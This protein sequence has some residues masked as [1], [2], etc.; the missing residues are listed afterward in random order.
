MEK[1]HLRW[2]EFETN[3]RES[4]RQ[5]RVDQ[6]HFDVTLATDDGHQIEAHKI[7]LS[8]G[9]QFFDNILRKTKHPS[10][11]VYLKGINRVELEH[12]IDFLYNGEA[13]IAQEE[14][15][16]FLETAQELHVKGL[17]SKHEDVSDQ[18][19][20]VNI[21]SDLEPKFPEI[22]KNYTRNQHPTQQESWKLEEL[23]DS[24]ANSD[25]SLVQTEEDNLLLNTNLEL[26]L[27][28]EQMI[29]K[30]EELWQC[31]VCGNT[32]KL[33]R[34]LQNHVETHIEGISHTCHVCNKTCSTRNSLKVH[35]SDYHSELSFNCNIC[36]KSGMAKMAFK[37]HKRTCKFSL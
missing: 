5:L 27:Q 30:N 32:A 6:S 2:N 11:F 26:D 19:Q 33:K 17:Q 24:F 4:F 28:I 37:I 12:V 34:N 1:L 20:R 15:N 31:K 18:N 14:L 36:G 25:V 3:I 9:S 29:E 23:A 16:K 7:I 22:E 8:A 35:I 13:Y 21:K 10:P